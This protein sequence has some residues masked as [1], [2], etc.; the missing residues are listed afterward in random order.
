[1][2]HELLV[3]DRERTG[4]QR[5]DERDPVGRIVDRRE[6]PDQAANLIALEEVPGSLMAVGDPRLCEG[7]FVEP[8]ARSC[9]QQ[10]RHVSPL[11]GAP[12]TLVIPVADLPPVAARCA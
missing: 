8:E 4:A 11:T 3:A 6:H 12:A 7:L 2:D 5:A 1:M 10:N 9:G